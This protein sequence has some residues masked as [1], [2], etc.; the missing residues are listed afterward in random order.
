MDFM[1]LVK[2]VESLYELCNK[3]QKHDNKVNFKN[4]NTNIAAQGRS[5]FT[6]M[7]SQ[8]ANVPHAELQ[9]RTVVAFWK[10]SKFK[11]GGDTYFK[12]FPTT[13]PAFCFQLAIG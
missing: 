7:M 12:F 10:T 6:L 13:F 4:A 1:K 8:N 11:T 9:L 5:S 3:V 2:F